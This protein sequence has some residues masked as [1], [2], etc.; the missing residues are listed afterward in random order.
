MIGRLLLLIA[1][2]ALTRPDGSTVWV[3]PTTVTAVATSRE[4]G[5][6]TRIWHLTG[7]Q[8]VRGTPAEVADKISGAL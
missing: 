5:G 7:S 6:L 4:C 1:L 3:N 8:C 2:V